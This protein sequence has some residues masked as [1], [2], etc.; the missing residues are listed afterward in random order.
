MV[1]TAK[2]KIRKHRGVEESP[3]NNDVLNTI[4]LFLFP[5]AVSEKP[6]DVTTSTDNNCPP[7]ESEDYNLYNQFKSAPSD[8]LTYK[9]ALCLCM[10]NFYHGGLKGVAHLWQEFVLEMRFRWENNFLIPGLAS[11]PPDLRCCLLHQKLQMLNCCIERKK[12]RDEGKKTSASDNVTNIYPGD[13]GKTGDQLGPDDLKE[14]DKDK[15]EVGKSWDSWS[16][17]E[18]EF[19]NA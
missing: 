15:G 9:L 3:L 2:K 17:S 14:T 5:D 18:E 1:H 10:I 7:S 6:L 13:A 4:L 19:L 16:D 12:A 8:S 11:G